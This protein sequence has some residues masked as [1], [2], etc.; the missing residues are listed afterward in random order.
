VNKKTVYASAVAERVR[1]HRERLR[2]AGLRPVQRWL[3][4]VRRPGFAAECRAQSMALKKCGKRRCRR[5]ELSRGDLVMVAVS[6]RT[7]GPRKMLVVQARLFE[8]LPTVT[9]L[10]VVEA[11]MQPQSGALVRVCVNSGLA[12][13]MPCRAEVMI[14]QA[15]A[16]PRRRIRF[17]VGRLGETDL[18]AVDRALAV[19]L[20]LA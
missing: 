6:G 15:Q 20:G 13:D 10:P 7:R 9:V 16:I 3:T 5:I 11:L 12:I 17:V 18:L 2:L 19:F 14:D 8:A 1:R 4:D